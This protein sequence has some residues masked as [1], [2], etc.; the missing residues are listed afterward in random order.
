MRQKSNRTFRRILNSL[1]VEVA[2]RYGYN[3]RPV[4]RLAERLDMAR[5]RGDWK[6]V[7]TVA[8]QLA[9]LSVGD[10]RQSP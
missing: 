6:E 5:A 7:V 4:D 10:E 2:V 3:E 9:E 1:P 8:Q